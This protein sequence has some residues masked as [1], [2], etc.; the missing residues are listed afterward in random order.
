MA[1]LHN[2]ARVTQAGSGD[3]LFSWRDSQSEIRPLVKKAAMA[4]VNDVLEQEGWNSTFGHSFRIGGASHFLAQK[5][6]PE[7][8][9]IAGRWRL[10]AYETYI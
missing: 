1:A 6:E 4:R 2:T 3:P 8:V 9:R 10:L 7:V 5:V